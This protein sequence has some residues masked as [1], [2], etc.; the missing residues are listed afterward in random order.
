MAVFSVAIADLPEDLA[1]GGA[2]P[3]GEDAWT[4]APLAN[5]TKAPTP[6]PSP[7][8]SPKPTAKA[9]KTASFADTVNQLDTSSKAG[10]GVGILIVIGCIVGMVCY[11]RQHKKDDDDEV[12][13]PRD[14]QLV[15]NTMHN[16]RPSLTA[17]DLHG[18]GPYQQ[19]GQQGQQGYQDPYAGDRQS[20]AQD[21]QAWEERQTEYQVRGVG[22]CCCACGCL[23]VPP[24]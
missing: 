17:A 7:R 1:S 23:L 5:P 8:P 13:G 9:V 18:T 2:L 24:F 3:H 22:C 20:E 21:L 10:I 6:L 12:D 16:A 4:Y 19:Q 15:S 14:I 11:Y